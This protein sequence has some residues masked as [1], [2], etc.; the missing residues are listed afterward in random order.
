MIYPQGSRRYLW[1][2]CSPFWSAPG[3]TASQAF[4]WFWNKD[5]ALVLPCNQSGLCHFVKWQNSHKA[6]I[7][8]HKRITGSVER[9]SNIQNCSFAS[10]QTVPWP[11]MQ[12][13]RRA[14]AWRLTWPPSLRWLLRVARRWHNAEASLLYSPAN[15]QSGTKA[16][17]GLQS[18]FTEVPSLPNCIWR[19]R[20][21]HV[22]EAGHDTWAM[23]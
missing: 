7:T 19:W 21:F 14:I 8:G 10:P 16:T 3:H 4:L 9:H 17:P 23:H 11:Q 13:G 20:P 15:G 2:S 22:T 5:G 12:E 6:R 1:S 18:P